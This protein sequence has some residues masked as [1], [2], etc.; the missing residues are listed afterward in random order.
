MQVKLCDPYL[1]QKALYKYSSFPFPFRVSALA[2]PKCCYCS[3]YKYHNPKSRFAPSWLAFSHDSGITGTC[4]RQSSGG[5]RAEASPAHCSADLRPQMLALLHCKHA[6][7]R[8]SWHSALSRLVWRVSSWSRHRRTDK[9]WTNYIWIRP[10]GYNGEQLAGHIYLLK[11]EASVR[12]CAPWSQKALTLYPATDCAAA[13]DIS[14]VSGR[15][16]LSR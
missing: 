1:G 8:P 15:W 10:T 2:G 11:F 14:G 5:Y 16:Q 6:G 9:L 12:L 13:T 4:G 7:V 3:Y